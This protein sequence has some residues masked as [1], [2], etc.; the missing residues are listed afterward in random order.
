MNVL[1]WFRLVH[2]FDCPFQNSH[3]GLACP[4]YKVFRK[5]NLVIYKTSPNNTFNNTFTLRLTCFTGL[6]VGLSYLR[7]HKFY[8]NIR[9]SLNS[10]CNC[11]NA[12]ESTKHYHLLSTKEDALTH[13]LLYG[14]NTLRDN[15]NTLILNSIIKY[16]TS[17]KR[18]NDSFVIIP[19]G[20]S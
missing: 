16:M 11:A 20:D 1:C 4:S 14:N 18:Y 10:I 7:Q 9:D 5:R 3:Y 17:T 12:I 13:L 2:L 6:R 19:L 8:H 15:T